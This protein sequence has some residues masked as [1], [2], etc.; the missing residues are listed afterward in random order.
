ML[1]DLI[2]IWLKYSPA[3]GQDRWHGDEDNNITSV[4]VSMEGDQWQR[5]GG[6]GGGTFT[7]LQHKNLKSKFLIYGI[8]I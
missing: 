6:G 8:D 3:P 4:Y 7:W 5:G 2:F 1:S